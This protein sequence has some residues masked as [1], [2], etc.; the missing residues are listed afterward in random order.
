ME[1]SVERE[2]VRQATDQPVTCRIYASSDAF[3]PAKGVLRNRSAEGAYIESEKAFKAGAVLILKIESTPLGGEHAV[4]MA[5]PRPQACL[6][7]V[8]WC[9]ELEGSPTLKYGMGLRQ[10][11]VYT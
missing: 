1:T 8:K 9:R 7:E 2:A 4:D 10:V 6:M 3:N 5:A 11:Q